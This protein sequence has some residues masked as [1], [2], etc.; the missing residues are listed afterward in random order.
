MAWLIWPAL[1]APIFGLM[2]G[3]HLVQHYHWRALFCVLIVLAALLYLTAQAW[4]PKLA[5]SG[6]IKLM[7]WTGYARWVCFCVLLFSFFIAAT[8]GSVVY[9]A[10]LLV[11]ACLSLLLL[12]R[13]VSRRLPFGLFYASLMLRASFRLNIIQGS[14]FVSAFTHFLS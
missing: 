6:A 8:S 5:Q 12:S 9:A 1:I 3:A 11:G 14:F 13:S 7:D 2:L 10:L 4:L